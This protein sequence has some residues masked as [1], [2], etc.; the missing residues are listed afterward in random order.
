MKIKWRLE[1]L[2]VH[3][4]LLMMRELNVKWTFEG[5]VQKAVIKGKNKGTEL[6]FRPF[7]YCILSTI[8]LCNNQ[9]I[10]LLAFLNQEIFFVQKVVCGNHLVESSKL[11]F[12]Q[13]NTTALNQLTHFA[14]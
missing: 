11:F 10:V 8:L 13:R 3:R 7:A 2:N 1:M 4:T 14:L 6:E 5:K 9:I 12:V